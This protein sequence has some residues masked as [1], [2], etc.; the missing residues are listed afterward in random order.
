LVTTF[1]LASRSVAVNCC[2]APIPRLAVAGL[3]VTDATGAVDAVVVPLATFD[4]APNTASTFNVPR[5]ATS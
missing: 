4:S 1:P 3:T 2:V 5:N